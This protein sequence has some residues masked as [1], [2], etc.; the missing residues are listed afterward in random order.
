[1]PEQANEGRQFVNAFSEVYKATR[2][3]ETLENFSVADKTDFDESQSKNTDKEFT[4]AED[5]RFWTSVLENPRDSFG[6]KVSVDWCTLSLW[7]PRVPGLYWS[8]QSAG[9]RRLSEE[10]IESVSGKWMHYDPTGKSFNIFGG[11]G[12]NMFA[13]DEQGNRLVC[14]TS[15]NDASLGIPALISGNVWDMMKLRDRSQVEIMKAPWQLMNQQ[16]ISR[17]P[18]ITGIP[19]A[20]LVID[21]TKYI[22]VKSSSLGFYTC[23]PYSIMEYNI[24][25]ATFYDYVY[26]ST[27]EPYENAIDKLK[28]FF[29]SYRRDKGRNG[30]YLLAADIYE[31]L[32]DADYISPADLR[33][34][35]LSGRSHLEILEEKIK[36]RYFKGML[37]DEVI[38]NINKF[39]DDED[40]IRRLAAYVDIPGNSIGGRTVSDKVSELVNQCIKANKLEI[41]IDKIAIERPLIIK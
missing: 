23:Q 19:K 9:M 15:G 4:Q 26:A 31:P 36:K 24:G 1:M 41:L 18:S 22:D 30:R 34:N 5:E 12:T 35:E 6:R 29:G 21:D 40:S 7:V 33:R 28:D 2:L 37:L 17:F 8:K 11:I 3:L 32:F 27:G 20:Y 39:Y 25:D 13:Q 10:H 16:W 38:V 14:L